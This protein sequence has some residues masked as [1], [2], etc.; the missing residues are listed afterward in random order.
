MEMSPN[1]ASETADVLA[2]H[3]YSL[4]TDEQE[5]T[6]QTELRYNAIRYHLTAKNQELILEVV[7]YP[8]GDNRYYLEIVQYLGLS[9]FSFELDSWRFRDD[10][11]EFRYY[12]NSETGE[13]LTIKLVYP[14][15]IPINKE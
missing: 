14:S 11:I 9:T 1:Y 10:H 6:N 7:S 8:N 13:A 15:G 12:T 3:G 4:K 2:N 5:C